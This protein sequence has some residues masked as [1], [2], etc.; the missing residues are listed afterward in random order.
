MPD[1]VAPL[2]TLVLAI[3]GFFFA[4]EG[5]GKKLSPLGYIILTVTIGSGL[6]ATHDA[7]QK[8]KG[9]DEQKA[10]IARL[11]RDARR[12]NNLNIAALIG[13]NRTLAIVRLF[14]NTE[15]TDEDA[16]KKRENVLGRAL[17]DNEFVPEKIA[18]DFHYGMVSKRDL[19]QI[20]T[21]TGN[22]LGSEI[23]LRMTPKSGDKF[24]VVQKV[25]STTRNYECLPQCPGQNTPPPAKAN[26]LES[27]NLLFMDADGAV[28]FYGLELSDGS[29]VGKIV[30]SLQSSEGAF[31]TIKASFKMKGEYSKFKWIVQAIRFEMKFYDNSVRSKKAE[32]FVAVTAPFISEIQDDASNLTTEIKLTGFDSLDINLCEAAP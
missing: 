17:A 28:S 21:I 14:G 7:I 22:F 15:S 19:G 24:A 32:C 20:V 26:K 8:S 29:S 6:F 3:L 2:L 27:T 10:T 11:Q 30:S 23:E 25:G 9:S 31:F 4:R 16:K 18:D 12:L 13:V 1:F 5:E